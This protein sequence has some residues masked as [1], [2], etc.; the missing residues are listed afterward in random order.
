MQDPLRTRKRKICSV[1]SQGL[2]KH[3]RAHLNFHPPLRFYSSFTNP[4]L[5]NYVPIQV[6][7]ILSNLCGYTTDLTEKDF[8]LPA[9]IS[10]VTDVT[11]VGEFIPQTLAR[12]H[13]RSTSRPKQ[14]QPNP[15]TATYK[16]LAALIL[17][18]IH[19][20]GGAVSYIP[21]IYNPK[22]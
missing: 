21:I 15:E 2:L 19:W 9:S 18:E 11:L 3:E 13:I 17:G 6:L 14:S 1:S 12:A 7:L 22:L 16:P 8:Q 4:S 5:G 10:G 20:L